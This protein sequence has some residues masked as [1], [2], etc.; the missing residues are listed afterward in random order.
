MCAPEKKN[1]IFVI[2]NAICT[3]I[4]TIIGALFLHSCMMQ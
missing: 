3:A 4:S 2:V 1:K